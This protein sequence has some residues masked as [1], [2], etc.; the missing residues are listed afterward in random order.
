MRNRFNFKSIAFRIWLY[1]LLFT[2]I[3]LSS[4]WFLQ[5]F[6]VDNYYEDMKIRHTDSVAAELVAAYNEE[7]LSEVIKKASS[8][9]SQD[10]LYVK[11]VSDGENVY[12]GFESDTYKDEIDRAAVKLAGTPESEPFAKLTVGTDTPSQKLYIHAEYINSSKTDMLYL[13]SPLYPMDSTINILQRQSVYIIFIALLLALLMTLY[14]SRTISEPLGQLTR[15]ARRLAAGDFSVEV[16][17]FKNYSEVNELGSTFNFL[18]DELERSQNMQRDLM[19][20]VSHDLRTPLTMIK[21]YAEMIRDL[22]GDDP[23]KRNSHL[24]V[25]IDE[26]DRLNKLV[27]DMLALTAMQSGTMSLDIE[28]FD[29]KEAIESVL[30]PYDVMQLN[31]GYEITFNCRDGITVNGDEER[32]KQVVSNLL[33]NAVKYCGEDK[34]I[35][36]N[37]RR[38]GSVVHCEV[39]DHGPGIKPEDLDRIWERHYRTSTNYA[40]STSGSGLGLSIVKE[41][42][43][44]HGSKFGV[45]SKVGRGTTV[46]FELKAAHTERAE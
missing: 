10:D 14:M 5:I 6:F 40:R 43:Q 20:N 27:N 3:I 29:I 16:P 28:P 12:P 42:L 45:E 41:I 23:E 9:T 19:A 24:Q 2:G 8:I 11:I 39:I 13:V 15:S 44:L 34:K 18:A 30:Q 32:I 38:W 4:M 1:M 33:T 22:S 17:S 21:S 35:I 31:E 36:I 37:V 7:D 46:W 25:I 26:S